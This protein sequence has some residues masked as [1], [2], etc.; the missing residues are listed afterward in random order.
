MKMKQIVGA[1]FMLSVLASGAARAEGLK[2]DAGK[3]QLEVPHGWGKTQ[4]ENVVHLADPKHEVLVSFGVVEA[5]NLK[6]T[7]EDV[8]KAMRQMTTKLAMGKT[9]EGSVHGMRVFKVGGEALLNGKPVRVWLLMIETPTKKVAVILTFTNKA[10]FDSHKGE[11]RT[12]FDSI[13]PLD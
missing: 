1:L 3:I 10:S 13:R 4:T 7:L 5:K 11:L 6:K 12:I 8:D 2:D 9:G